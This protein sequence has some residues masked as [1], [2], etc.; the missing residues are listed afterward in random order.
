MVKLI[1]KDKNVHKAGAWEKQIP[2][3][4]GWYPKLRQCWAKLWRDY[5]AQT[6]DGVPKIEDT[7]W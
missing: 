2:S 1:N 3:P 4:H 5:E 6:G 7:L